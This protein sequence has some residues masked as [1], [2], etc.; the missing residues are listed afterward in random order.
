MNACLST[1]DSE[2]TGWI[3][4]KLNTQIAYRAWS[5]MSYVKLTSQT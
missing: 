3:S 1:I 5:V 2:T 4:T